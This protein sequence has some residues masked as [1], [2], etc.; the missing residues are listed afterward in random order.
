MSQE[1][2]ISQLISTLLKDDYATAGKQ[3]NNIM[4]GKLSERVR[5]IDAKLEEGFFDRVAAKASGAKAGIKAGIKNFGTKVKGGSKAAGQMLTGKFGKAATTLQGT[6]KAANKNDPKKAA[7]VA[8]LASIT[9]SVSKDL[10]ALFP[11]DPAVAKALAA[12]VNIGKVATSTPPPL[13]RKAP[14]KR[15]N[16]PKKP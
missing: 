7:K 8:K 2:Q 10:N 1:K 16:L 13:P 4:A 14:A 6:Q 3:L 9:K 11:G 12:L 5:D 15:V